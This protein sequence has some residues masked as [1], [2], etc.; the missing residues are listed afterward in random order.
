MFGASELVWKK[1]AQWSPAWCPDDLPG[2]IGLNGNLN[3]S[4]HR[5]AEQLSENGLVATFGR[6]NLRVAATNVVKVLIDVLLLQRLSVQNSPEFACIQRFVGITQRTRWS[7][8]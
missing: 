3:I 8:G 2:K 6:W 5:S 4:T 1:W 7:I